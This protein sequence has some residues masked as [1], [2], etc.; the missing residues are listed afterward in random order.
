MRESVSQ[1][2]GG[3]TGGKRKADGSYF[4]FF[5]WIKRC[6]EKGGN[7]AE[8][9]SVGSCILHPWYSTA[10]A[11]YVEFPSFLAGGIVSLLWGI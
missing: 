5:L 3:N 1:C 10:S 6:W 9:F 8:S 11:W 4:Q 2:A 7:C